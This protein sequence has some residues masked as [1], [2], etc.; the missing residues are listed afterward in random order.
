MS[1]FKK[2]IFYR[3]RERECVLKPQGKY[4]GQHG[5]AARNTLLVLASNWYEAPT[6]ADRWDLMD[7][8]F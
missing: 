7:Q 5:S 3:E 8:P 2:I 6:A 4:F 1:I